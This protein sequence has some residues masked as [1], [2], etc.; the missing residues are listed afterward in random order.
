MGLF[1]RSEYIK[2]GPGISKNA[3]EKKPFF[4]FT[5]L[6]FRKIGKLVKVNLLVHC[7]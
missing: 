4:Q 2:A 1:S 5:E 3:P 6:Y 7:L